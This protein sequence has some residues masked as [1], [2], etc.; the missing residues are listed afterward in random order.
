MIGALSVNAL[1]TAGSDSTWLK[2]EPYRQEPYGGRP[3]TI[4]PRPKREPDSDM[5]ATWTRREPLMAIPTRHRPMKPKREPLSVPPWLTPIKPSVVA[6]KPG[7]PKGL[8]REP[9][10]EPDWDEA[11]T[12]SEREPEPEP[13]G[14]DME[15]A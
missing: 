6:Y 11:H 5:D 13:W 3:K 15:E 12:F 1:T 8:K 14:D 9:Y 10:P 2:R 7:P 4:Q